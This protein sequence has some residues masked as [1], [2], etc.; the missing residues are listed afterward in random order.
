M[1]VGLFFN[2]TT[3]TLNFE[4]QVDHYK[5]SV[6]AN[7]ETLSGHYETFFKSTATNDY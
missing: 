2:L 5:I 4:L 6:H 3:V 7:T 1:H